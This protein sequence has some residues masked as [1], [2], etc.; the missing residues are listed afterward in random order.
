MENKHVSSTWYALALDLISLNSHYKPYKGNK[1]F[2]TNEVT[3]L[4]RVSCLM[5]QS[6]HIGHPQKARVL[7]PLYCVSCHHFSEPRAETGQNEASYECL[8]LKEINSKLHKIEYRQNK[9]NRAITCVYILT[10]KKS[11][12]TVSPCFRKE[13]PMQCCMLR[14]S[15]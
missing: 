2:F 7:S 1:G 13:I 5:S 12:K 6:T 3:H 8:N 11:K 15:K 10:L 14:K 4:E 9:Q